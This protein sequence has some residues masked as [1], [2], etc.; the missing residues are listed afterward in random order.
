M[1]RRV[2]SSDLPFTAALIIEVDAWL[3]EQPWPAIF[4]SL[5]MSVSLSTSM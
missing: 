3:M 5:T 2:S 1:R 4:T